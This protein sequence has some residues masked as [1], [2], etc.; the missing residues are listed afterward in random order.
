MELLCSFCDWLIKTG[1]TLSTQQRVCVNSVINAKYYSTWEHASWLAGLGTFLKPA[2]ATCW[3]AQ[4]LRHSRDTSVKVGIKYK[5]D[6]SSSSN[7]SKRNQSFGVCLFNNERFLHCPL[8]GTPILT[9]N[10]ERKGKIQTWRKK[11][12]DGGLVHMG[13]CWR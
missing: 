5:K 12:I 11:I 1:P 10:K 2:D 8:W 7:K 9:A 13:T 6:L 3:D 4:V